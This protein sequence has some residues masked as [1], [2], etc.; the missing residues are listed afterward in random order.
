MPEY[1]GSIKIGDAYIGGKK[2][3]KKY[4]G[5]N[6]FYSSTIPVGTLLY[7]EPF[8][9]WPKYDTDSFHAMATGPSPIKVIQTS[10][11]ELP[12]PLSK[13]KTGIKIYIN[14]LLALE[15]SYPSASFKVYS[16]SKGQ[17]VNYTGL[18]T[19]T[20]N[21]AQPIILPKGSFNANVLV[22]GFTYVGFGQKV[23]V[24]QLDDTHITFF[25]GIGIK[26]GD[27]AFDDG[28]SNTGVWYFIIDKIEAY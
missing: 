10:S 2:V 23:Y 3:S 5:N 26:Q 25:G 18:G 7:P 14:R 9:M 28:S 15:T 16:F 24:K 6:L 27:T 17:S 1:R 8:V 12:K 21:I 20:S 19:M 13:L 22:A 11:I 4:R